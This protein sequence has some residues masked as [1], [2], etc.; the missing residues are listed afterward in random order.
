MKTLGEKI[1][2]LR[3]LRDLSLRELANKLKLSAAF[4]SDIEL[5]RRNPSDKVLL[6]L[7]RELGVSIEELRTYDPR[8]LIDDIKRITNSEPMYGLAFRKV[9]DEVFK[10]KKS[11]E[12]IMKLLDHKSKKKK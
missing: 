2:E 10:N 1:R 11:P 5:G 3:E 6:D 9:V 7:A 12:E 8:P 4:L